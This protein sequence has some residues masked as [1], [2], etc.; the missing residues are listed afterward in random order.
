M[1]GGIAQ[2]YA[3]YEQARSQ[4]EELDYNAAIAENEAVAVMYAMKSQLAMHKRAVFEIIDSTRAGAVGA[5][6]ELAGTPLEVIME[7]AREGEYEQRM[8]EYEGKLRMLGLRNEAELL[9]FQGRTAIET[10]KP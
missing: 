5:G 6:V 9:R 4:K 8:I 3:R 1:A 10:G 7:A 2:G